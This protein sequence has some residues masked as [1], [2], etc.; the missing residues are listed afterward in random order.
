MRSFNSVFAFRKYTQNT[1]RSGE[2]AVSQRAQVLVEH[3]RGG[4]IVERHT[5]E[6]WCDCCEEIQQGEGAS[7]LGRLRPK[8]TLEPH[9]FYAPVPGSN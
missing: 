6:E 5:L 2:T 9:K 1:W 4:R 7:D 8:L 3:R